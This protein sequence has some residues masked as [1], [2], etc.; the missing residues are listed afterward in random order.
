MFLRYFVFLYCLVFC[1]C[2]FLDDLTAK[3]SNLSENIS[4]VTKSNTSSAKEATI[5]FEYNVQDLN[6]RS[7]LRQQCEQGDPRNQLQRGTF[8]INL[9]DLSQYKYTCQQLD[10]SLDNGY[11]YKYNLYSNDNT[12]KTNC[13]LT[14]L[15][16][17][18][19]IRNNNTPVV[20]DNTTTTNSSNIPTISLSGTLDNPSNSL[21]LNTSKI[22]SLIANYEFFLYIYSIN[23][24]FTHYYINTTFKC[25]F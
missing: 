13:G 12:I 21:V 16:D 4:C 15:D 20:T 6:L 9:C 11:T 14:S 19:K 25:R 5:C 7:I 23:Y 1:A 17:D 22:D 3:E 18:T 2:E 8:Q 24:W 10:A